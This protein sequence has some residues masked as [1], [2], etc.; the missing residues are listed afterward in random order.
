VSPRFGW[1]ERDALDN[2]HIFMATP[3]TAGIDKRAN[4][5]YLRTSE[6]FE[7][8]DGADPIRDD[9]I[10][11]VA[12]AFARWIG[13]GGFPNPITRATHTLGSRRCGRWG[14]GIFR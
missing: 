10:A 6:G 13:D 2:Y 1:A 8:L 4:P 3:R 12:P 14:T 7:I 9:E 11:T 5:V